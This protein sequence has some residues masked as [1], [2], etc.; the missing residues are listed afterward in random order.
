MMEV[1]AAVI[2]QG[3]KFLICQRSRDKYC[4]LLR[5]F[6]G[7]KIK[8]CK[9][10]EECI[11]RECREEFGVTLKVHGKFCDTVQE[12]PDRVVHHLHFFNTEIV[13]GE[14]TPLEH[15]AVAWVTQAKTARHKFCPADVKMLREN[16][17]G[18]QDFLTAKEVQMS[19]SNHI[20][21][22]VQ[23]GNVLVIGN[24]GV[25]KS[26]L[27]NTVLGEDLAEVDRRLKGAAKELKTVYQTKSKFVQ[28]NT[29]TENSFNLL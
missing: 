11:T 19:E 12:H 4:G 23:R 13:S 18:T 10:A 15:N 2:W 25:G 9:T 28:E 5:E 20:A 24:S 29:A 6:S 14:L 21:A 17:L 22:D 26:T 3:D 16:T 8:P 27:I 7:G 1:T